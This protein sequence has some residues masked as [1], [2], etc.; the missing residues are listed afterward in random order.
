MN[1]M[2][3]SIRDFKKEFLKSYFDS[4]VWFETKFAGIK[5]LKSVTDL[6]NYQE[7]ICEIKPSLIVEFGTLYGGSTLYFAHILSIINQNFKIFSVDI[8]HSNTDKLVKSHPNIE[9]CTCSSTDLKLIKRI[10]ELREKYSGNI[11]A[12]IDSDHKKNHVLA[13]M[14]LLKN[15]LY[16]GDYLVVEDGIV[17]GNPIMEDFGEGPFEAINE[18]MKLNPNDFIIDEKREKKFGM[19]FAPSGYLIKQ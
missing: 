5:C 10:K 11:F 14:N 19:T 1:D 2:D 16:R 7:I 3:L 17:N 18:F 9:L 12:I 4:N 15:V 6:W 8:D 13:E